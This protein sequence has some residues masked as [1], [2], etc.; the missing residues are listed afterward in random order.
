VREAAALALNELEDRASLELPALVQKD[1]KDAAH[2]AIEDDVPLYA[3][4]STPAPISI[5]DVFS[6]L[7]EETPEI[8]SYERPW[9]SHSEIDSRLMDYDKRSSGRT[10]SSERD[11]HRESVYLRSGE[12]Q[13]QTRNSTD[14]DKIVQ[15]PIRKRRS[16]SPQ[17][18][19]SAEPLSRWRIIERGLVAALIVGIGFSWLFLSQGI[20]TTTSSA[21]ALFSYRDKSGEASSPVWMSYAASAPNKDKTL[22]AF[23]DATG[24]VQVWDTISKQHVNEYG[25]F[26]KVLAMAYSVHGLYIAVLD[27]DGSLLLMRA[28]DTKPLLS[29]RESPG[30][31]PLVVWAPDGSRIA[32]ALNTKIDHTVQVWN[33]TTQH[34][35]TVHSGHS[36][37]ITSIAWSQ[38]GT[39]IATASDDGR[40]RMIELWGTT[41]GKPVAHPLPLPYVPVPS[42]VVAMAW[43]ADGAHL[44]YALDDGEV[45]V[46]DSRTYSHILFAI[47]TTDASFNRSHT[48]SNAKEVL[49]WSPNGQYLASTTTSGLIQIWDEVTGNLLYTYRGHSRQVNDMVWSPD[50]KH[51]ASL[52]VDGS[53]LVWGM[54]EN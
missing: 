2:E 22:L 8:P 12:Q 32:V 45:R 34:R 52:G 43:S 3:E 50:G 47:Y 21:S 54:N 29:L 7:K 16:R 33:V 24:K 42:R 23:A 19:T 1:E 38:D 40:T 9:Y 37:S 25:P 6:R 26:N 36:G 11:E 5:E 18:G 49:A 46:W 27:R 51:V 39:S 20:N 17:K 13:E 53:V 10:N 30:M 14:E 35:V 15:L 44:A 28:G 31:V 48:A 41:T 4:R